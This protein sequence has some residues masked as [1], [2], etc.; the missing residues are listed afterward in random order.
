MLRLDE[1]VAAV[2]RLDP[3]SVAYSRRIHEL[4]DR[5]ES[6][7]F[8]LAVLG[9]FKRGKSS[10]I[11]ALLGEALLPTGIPPLTAIPTMI[12]AGP[13]HRVTVTFERDPVI[14]LSAGD[15]AEA[16]ELLRRYIAEDEN[17]RNSREVTRVEVSS[18][19]P[20]LANG[21]VLIDTPGVGSTF[22]HNSAT[23]REFLPECDAALFVVSADPPITEAEVEFLR[24]VTAHV[25]R[26]FFVM[27]KADYLDEREQKEAVSFLR[28]TLADEMEM[29]T[30]TPIFVVS[31][32]GARGSTASLGQG[33]AEL[34]E[35]IGRFLVEEKNRALREALSAKI[36]DCARDALARIDLAIRASM[37]PLEDLE[38]RL[39]AFQSFAERSREERRLAHDGITGDEQRTLLS[40][41]E[42]M[43]ELRDRAMHHFEEAAGIR[44]AEADG[45]GEAGTQ[46]AALIPGYFEAAAADATRHMAETLASAFATHSR[47]ANALLDDVRKTASEVFEV[48]R[49]SHAVS[50]DS[51]LKERLN[52]VTRPWSVVLSPIPDSVVDGL[53]PGAV[54]AK[55]IRNRV[56]ANLDELVTRNVEN[57]R[58]SLIRGV[59]DSYERMASELDAAIELEI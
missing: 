19:S 25:T 55:R 36:G 59:K 47:R 15:A 31:S 32:R 8:H 56:M 22:R 17:P 50:A 4:R 44:L 38:N 24:D 12:V 14:E 37:L 51:V 54:R 35:Y 28:R 41:E 42:S 18:A 45:S 49:V 11:N 3:P 16:C 9:Q 52:W 10:L 34:R 46:V 40:L 48:P 53:L 58:W 7:R 30:E 6:G 43:R 13:A 21:V 1:L 27:N 2:D 20:V 39:T 26:V 33:M 57:L 5:A 29:S 23:T